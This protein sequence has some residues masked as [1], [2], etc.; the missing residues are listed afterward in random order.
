MNRKQ[1]IAALSGVV[2]VTLLV[3]FLPYARHSAGLPVAYRWFASKPPTRIVS[4]EADADDVDPRL[5][6]HAT[7]ELRTD[8]PPVRE[9]LTWSERRPYPV[10]TLVLVA[11]LYAVIVLTIVVVHLLRDD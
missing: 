6:E 10:A 5:R 7:V 2:V 4:M 1:M 9:V 3:M 8:P 11:S